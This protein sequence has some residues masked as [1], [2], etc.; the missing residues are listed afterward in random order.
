MDETPLTVIEILSPGDT[1]RE[2]MQRFN[3]YTSLGV[4]HIVQM[5]PE[6]QVAHRFQAGSLIQTRFETLP[7]EQRTIPFDSEH[8]FT[9]LRREI[10]EAAAED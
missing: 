9:E 5:D 10:E 3:D 4:P 8:L 6:T 7:F 1:V 2:T